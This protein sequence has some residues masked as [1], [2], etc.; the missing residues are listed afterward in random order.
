MIRNHLVASSTALCSSEFIHLGNPLLE[1][2]V[3]ALLVAM[4]LVL[5]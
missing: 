3:L 4:P 1:F 5:E 2:L